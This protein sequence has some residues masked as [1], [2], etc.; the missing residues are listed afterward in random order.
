M[1]KEPHQFITDSEGKRTHVLL[2]IE[3]YEELL[4]QILDLEDAQALRQRRAEGGERV[5]LDDL[6]KQLGL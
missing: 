1:V 6:K 2:T 3:E 4:D 5:S